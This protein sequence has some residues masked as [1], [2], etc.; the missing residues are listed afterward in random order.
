[1]LTSRA[2]VG[3]SPEIAEMPG[4]NVLVSGVGVEDAGSNSTKGNDSGS[5]RTSLRI[6]RMDP[7]STQASMKDSAC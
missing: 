2:V 7:S 6:T 1:M 3:L 4:K 5:K